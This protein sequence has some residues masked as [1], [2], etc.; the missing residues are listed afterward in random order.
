MFCRLKFEK[1]FFNHVNISDFHL[2]GIELESERGFETILFRKL[3]DRKL[4]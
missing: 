1:N 2:V 3:K 4:P